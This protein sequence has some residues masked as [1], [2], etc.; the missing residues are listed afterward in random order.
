MT[1]QTVTIPIEDAEQCAR[2][3]LDDQAN[4]MTSVVEGIVIGGAG[5]AVAGLTVWLVQRIHSLVNDCRHGTRIYAWLK[6]EKDQ[7]GKEFRST[8]AIASWNNLTED[9]VRYICSHHSRIYLST[10][11][12]QDMW[13]IDERKAR[14][15]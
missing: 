1:I 5:G 9:R 2:P 8:R 4:K 10:G 13:S 12:N 3:T 7:G 11:E 6:K 14:G 15:S